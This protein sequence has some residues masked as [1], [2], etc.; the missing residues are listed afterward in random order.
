V[1]FFNYNIRFF[2]IIQLFFLRVWNGLMQNGANNTP[3]KFVEVEEAYVGQRIDNFLMTYLKTLPKT[4]LYRLLRKGEVRVN[5]KRIEP[6]YR[7]QA[8][9]LIRLPPMQ[10]D[11]K[12]ALSATPSA[13]LVTL[14][15][16]SILYED[17][18][19][20]IINKP[21]GIPVHGGTNVSLGV[22]EALRI[23]YP[24]LKHLELAHRLD[25]DTSGCLIVAKKRGILKEIH[26]L[27]RSGQVHK[28]YFALTKG[29][30]KPEELRVEVSLLKNHLSSGERIVRVDKEGKPSLTV[31][32]PVESFKKA[33]LVEATLHTGRTHQIRVHARY[34]SHPIA[35]DDKYGDKEFNKLLREQG[36]R[37]MF[38]HAHLLEF[39]IPSRAEK[40]SVTAPMDDELQDCLTQ[41]RKLG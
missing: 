24:M 15:K 8:G 5:K 26:E 34:R 27:M 16:E 40:I 35:G 38:L 20:L 17:D 1:I 21:A 19:L 33:M 37:R 30:W 25:R 6:S 32:A 4:R 2:V 11:A 29:Q 9:D 41:L 12:P 23:I 36:F 13:R 3:V 31:F 39:T 10:L 22:I 18:G 7:L 28:V 14:L